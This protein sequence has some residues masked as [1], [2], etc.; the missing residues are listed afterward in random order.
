MSGKE[1]GE[2]LSDVFH[3]AAGESVYE[4][5]DEYAEGDG[6]SEEESP[7]LLPVEV[8]EGNQHRLHPV[9][10]LGLDRPDG[11]DFQG[12]GHRIQVRERSNAHHDRECNED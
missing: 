3:E 10:L 1:M 6:A 9:L 5:H 4:G 12:D 7:L 2:V 11:F 8:S